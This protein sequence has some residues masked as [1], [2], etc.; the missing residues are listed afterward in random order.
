M[1][2]GAVAIAF[3]S[4]P[5]FRAY[6]S[7]GKSLFAKSS[8]SGV[9]LRAHPPDLTGLPENYRHQCETLRQV[10]AEMHR[11]AASGNQILVLDDND[12]LLYYLSGVAPWSRYASLFHSVMTQQMLRDTQTE[13]LSRRPAVIFIRAQAPLKWPFD[14]VLA[15]YHSLLDAHYKLQDH[16]G[17]YEVWRI[18]V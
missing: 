14:D 18:G 8:P 11:Q 13:I 6:P 4:K 1:L 2:G 16:I 12:T 3:W 5:Q 7:L 10:A 17:M 15:V 9:A